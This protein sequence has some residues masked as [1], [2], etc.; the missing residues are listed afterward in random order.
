M[1]WNLAHHVI[2]I[3]ENHAIL[4]GSLSFFVWNN[5]YSVMDDVVLGQRSNGW[6]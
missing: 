2:I 3:F 6:Y 4:A 5:K 1:R